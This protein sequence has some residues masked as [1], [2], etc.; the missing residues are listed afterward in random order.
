MR[1]R[2]IRIDKNDPEKTANIWHLVTVEPEYLFGDNAGERL[3]LY[4]DHD[5]REL[6]SYDYEVLKRR[7]DSFMGPNYTTGVIESGIERITPIAPPYNKSGIERIN[8]KM[9][10]LSAA[11]GEVRRKWRSEVS[12]GGFA[13]GVEAELPVEARVPVFTFRNFALNTIIMIAELLLFINLIKGFNGSLLGVFGILLSVVLF[14]ILWHGMKKLILH[15]NPARSFKTLGTAVYK[16]LSECDLISPSARVETVAHKEL[17]YVSLHLRN[18][19]I[20]DQNIF[21]TAMREM[22]SPIENPRY[23]LIAKNIFKRYNYRYSFACPTVIGKKKE[24]VAVL[25]ERLKATTGRFEP[26]YAHRDGGRRLILKC[27]K[28]SYI[29]LNEKASER[30]YKV[31]HFN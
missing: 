24:Y 15:F 30:K 29:T 31:S 3:A 27:R 25:A 26:V 7:F 13:V 10:A 12:G 23:I 19:S 14:V 8:E 11:R 28:H 22:L 18:A 2:A 21:N 4:L 5:N 16:T 1:G 9:L 6:H 20:H 17:E